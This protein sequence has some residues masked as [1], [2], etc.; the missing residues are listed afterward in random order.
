MSDTAFITA[1]TI[2]FAISVVALSLYYFIQALR[3]RR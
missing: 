3:A 2:A 1:L